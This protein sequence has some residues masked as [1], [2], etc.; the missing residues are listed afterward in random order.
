MIGNSRKN[1]ESLILVVDPRTTKII[2]S[3]CSMATVMDAGV[4]V[5][6]NIEILRK[7]VELGSLYFIEPSSNNIRILISDFDQKKTQYS[8]AYL[9]FSSHVADEEMKQ[10]SACKKLVSKIKVFKELNCDFLT[11]ESRVFSFGRFPPVSSLY[12]TQLPDLYNK[13]IYKTAQQLASVC[14]SLSDIP[15]IR[16]QARNKN[17][18][19][20]AQRV[21]I[22]MKNI[23]RQMPD[24]KPNE[25]RGQGTLLIVDR[26]IDP[27]TPLLHEFTYQAMIHDVFRCEGDYVFIP[28]PEDKKDEKKR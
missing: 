7:K 26:T 28:A 19:K 17:C 21:N 11:V 10:M 8:H 5:I 4:V 12:L 6:Q 23:V 2:S 24:W 1:N 27:F 9:F 3:C 22:E 20:L 13:E 15:Y 25:N 16:Y 18:E 14:F